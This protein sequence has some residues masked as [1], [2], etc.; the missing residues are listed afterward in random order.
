MI[1]KNIRL[2]AVLIMLVS[3]TTMFTGCGKKDDSEV[4]PLTKMSKK[5]LF[6]YAKDLEAKNDTLLERTSELEEMLKGIQ[7]ED[8]AVPSISTF[9]DGS[10][11][12]TLNSV[13]GL[14]TLPGEFLYPYS[15]Q[16]FAT[17]SINVSQTVKIIPSSNWI[18]T[19]DGT[20]TNLQH[21]GSSISGKF[22]VGGLSVPVGEN[23]KTPAELTDEINKFFENMP[24]E[25]IKFTRIYVNESW[26][27]MDAQCHTFINEEDANL[28]CGMLS[29]GQN[30]VVYMFAYKGESDNSKNEL[31]Q[32]LLT[33]T[34]VNN[35]AL[36]IE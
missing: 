34:S 5:E 7:G 3:L 13:D 33:S 8:I 28:R 25:N 2:L 1:H 6:S 10:G 19:L 36:R 18:I 31:I 15:V 21:T 17:S 32:N 26:V 35:S 4:D 14:V 24:P 20:T 30:T 22:V 12:L 16:T 23:A 27:G 29:V 11:R 9:K